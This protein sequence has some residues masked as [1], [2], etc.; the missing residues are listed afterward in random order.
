M[1]N[2]RKCHTQRCAFSLCMVVHLRSAA[3]SPPLIE[4][5]EGAQ[6]MYPERKDQFGDQIVMLRT[7]IGLTQAAFAGAVCV[8]RR[9]VQNW[10]NGISYPKAEKLQQIIAVFL[11]QRAFTP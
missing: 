11:H 5:G 7:R 4:G 3:R 10:E 6:L 9:S 8:H 1:V 2:D